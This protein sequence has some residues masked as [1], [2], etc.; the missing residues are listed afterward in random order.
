LDGVRTLLRTIVKEEIYLVVLVVVGGRVDKR[1]L[2]TGM[3]EMH[4]VQ[5]F[6]NGGVIDEEEGEAVQ[7]WRFGV[8]I[9]KVHTEVCGE[10]VGAN[11]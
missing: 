1:R 7:S 9:S 8:V 6:Q 4:E 2:W 11:G 5:G 10:G 3:S